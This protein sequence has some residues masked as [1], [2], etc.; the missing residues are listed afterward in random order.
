MLAR[1]YAELSLRDKDGNERP[2][3]AN[4]Q[5]IGGVFGSGNVDFKSLLHALQSIGYEGFGSLKIYRNAGFEEGARSSIEYLR[6][7]S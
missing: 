3:P 1:H 4:D 6:S 5:S 7:Q 2:D